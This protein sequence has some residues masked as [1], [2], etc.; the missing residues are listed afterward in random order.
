[1]PKYR[2][3]GVGVVIGHSLQRTPGIT[4]RNMFDINQLSRITR[5]GI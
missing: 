5:E 2:R 4:G 1:V 3:D